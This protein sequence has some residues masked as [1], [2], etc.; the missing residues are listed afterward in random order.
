MTTPNADEIRDQLLCA[1]DF[2]YVVG[3]LGYSTPEE[4]LVAYDTS[5]TPQPDGRAAVYA[6]AAD[7][8]KQIADRHVTAGH[9]QRALGAYD[10]EAVLRKVA[11]MAEEAPGA[12]DGQE[13]TLLRWGL[14]DLEYGDDGS[15]TV[16]LSGP[17]GEPYW[18]ELEPERAA[19]LRDGLAGPDGEESAVDRAAVLSPAEQ[20]M[21]RFALDLTQEHLLSRGDE[22]TDDHQAVLE[23][24]RRMADQAQQDGHVYLS[25]SCLHGE[26]GYCQSH[27]GLSGAKKPARC[28][29]CEAPCV[30]DCHQT[31]GAQQRDGARS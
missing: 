4:L 5:R 8:A 21:L 14:D 23:K 3:V 13:P 22:F 26:H 15:V 19:A 27:T 10:V 12:T 25:T 28:K 9:E 20:N 7:T 24:L 29:F 18:L 2:N 30:C 17:A 31:T 11:R 1:I 6:E 16:L